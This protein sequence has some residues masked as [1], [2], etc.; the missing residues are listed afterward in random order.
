MGD[1]PGGEGRPPVELSRDHDAR[2]DRRA[3]LHRDGVSLGAELGAVLPECHR[4]RVVLHHGR[5]PEALREG[6]LHGKSRP[7]RHPRR[8]PHRASGLHRAG[9]R[10]PH[11][12]QFPLGRLVA[13][14]RG[15]GTEH[16][17][18]A[19]GHRQGRGRGVQQPS[20]PVGHPEPRVVAAQFRH[21]QVSGGTV[22]AEPAAGASA[23]G[24][25]QSVLNHDP[26]VDELPDPG[27]GGRRGDPQQT[28]DVRTRRGRPVGQQLRDA[29][30]WTC[31]GLTLANAELKSFAHGN[32]LGRPSRG[33]HP[34][35]GGRAGLLAW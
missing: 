34:P 22:E 27:R 32:F 17:L 16:L 25:D 15:E 8:Q 1:V 26:R 6:L 30:M 9:Q 14:E 23:S 29:R 28:R 10:Q 18:R 7:S 2:T 4:V 5:H 21:Q 24:C 33:N 35:E 19:I 31:H 13:Q 20:R 11:P 3:R 12:R